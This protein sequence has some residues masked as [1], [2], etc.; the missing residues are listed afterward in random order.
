MPF[1]RGL[2]GNV[3]GR[4]LGTPNKMT[5]EHREFIQSI[6]D[7][8]KDKILIELEQLKGKD[9]IQAITTLLEFVIPKLS[10]TE[11]KTEIQEAENCIQIIQLPDNGRDVKN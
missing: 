7:N 10:R 11:L 4:P 1:I 9:Y 2:S 3:N 6:I 8:Q 5:Q